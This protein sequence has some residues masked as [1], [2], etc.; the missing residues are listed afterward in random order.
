[1]SARA[2][3]SA[4][5]PPEPMPI[6]P[7]SGSSTS[8]VPVSTSEVSLVG[9]GHHGLEAAQVAVGAPV[10]GELHAGAGQLARIGLELALEP[11]EQGQRVGGGAGET[12]DHV[13]LAE[14]AHLAGVRLDHGLAQADLAVAGDHDLRRPCGRKGS[15]CRA[16][17][18]LYLRVSTWAKRFLGRAM[19]RKVSSGLGQAFDELALLAPN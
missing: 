8:P 19:R 3:A 18:R 7:C 9:D 10:L 5:D 2:A 12:G 17:F 15:W 6:R 1:M 14:P 16:R 11:L 13:A 4:K